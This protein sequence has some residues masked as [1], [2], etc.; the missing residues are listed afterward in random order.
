[1]STI[2]KTIVDIVNEGKDITPAQQKWRDE[3]EKRS[4]EVAL[5]RR[6]IEGDQDSGLNEKMRKL[7]NLDS[8]QDFNFNQCGTAVA[9]LSNRLEVISVAADLGRSAPGGASIET[10]DSWASEVLQWN[11]FD[12]LQID[13]YDAAIRD[14]DGYIMIGWDEDEKMPVLTHELAFDG[15]NGMLVIH[16]R[17]DAAIIDIAVKIWSETVDATTDVQRVNVY[18]PDRVEKY[19]V[20]QGGYAVYDD[21]AQPGMFPLPWVDRQGKSIGVPI[22]QFPNRSIQKG[23][24]GVSK[25]RDVVP[26]QHALNV[27]MHSMVGT[28]LLGAFPINV[29]IGYTAPSVVEPGMF[30][31]IAPTDANKKVMPPSADLAEWLKAIRIEQIKGASLTDYIKM[32]ELFERV[33]E[34][35]ANIPNYSQGANASGESMKQRE[36][37]LLAEVRRAHVV[38]GAAWHRVLQLAAAVQNAYGSPAPQVRR[39]RANWKSG[40]TRNDVERS[41]VLSA[42]SKHLE[43]S[44]EM[45]RQIGALLDL[46]AERIEEIKAQM[47]SNRRSVTE[48]LMNRMPGFGGS[49]PG[50]TP[51][52]RMN[53]PA[54]PGTTGAPIPAQPV[55]AGEPANA[56]ANG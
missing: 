13:L 30:Y 46:S 22:V 26:L 33:I 37:E 43:G 5:Y 42:V 40:E 50:Q 51:A 6:Y 10:A 45:V 31:E 41:Q 11:E 53:N 17:Y 18:Y 8:K 47:D 29:F 35:V 25:L 36:S 9:T 2:L 21:P 52:Q 19:V 55:T 48:T 12:G 14:G 38:F 34:K 44:D 3:N 4:K 16:N 23:G 54:A 15:T 49:A 20:K 7:L 27:T 39:W 32:V 24:H 28:G 1:M 56:A